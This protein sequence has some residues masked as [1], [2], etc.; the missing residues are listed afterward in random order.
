MKKLALLSLI[1]LLF[2]TALVKPQE[3]VPFLRPVAKNLKLDAMHT[4]TFR[5]K[6]MDMFIIFFIKVPLR[7]R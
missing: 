5:G 2:L 3:V 6:Q 4:Q 7:K 1:S